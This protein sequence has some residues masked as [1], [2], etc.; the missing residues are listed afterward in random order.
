MGMKKIWDKVSGFLVWMLV[1]L[2]VAMMIFTVI[3][4]NTFNRNDRNIFGYKAYIVLSDSMSAT[5]DGMG[6]TAVYHTGIIPVGGTAG[7]NITII[8]DGVE[9]ALNHTWGASPDPENPVLTIIAEG[10][11]KQE[12]TTEPSES[13]GDPNLV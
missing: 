1:I 3:S 7:V 4:V 5:D 13:E 12:E 6:E 10:V 8:G 11:P 2:A 9:L